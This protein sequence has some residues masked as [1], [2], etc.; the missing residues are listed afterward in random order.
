MKNALLLFSVLAVTFGCKKEESAPFN[1]TEPKALWVKFDAEEQ[2]FKTRT[3]LDLK[4][5]A[6]PP[7]ADTGITQYMI[8]FNGDGAW[9][10]WIT[11]YNTAKFELNSKRIRKDIEVR[12][13]YSIVQSIPDGR[14]LTGKYNNS[15]SVDSNFLL[16]YASPLN[17]PFFDTV[18]EQKF[19][20]SFP[21]WFEISDSLD[22][23]AESTEWKY[24]YTASLDGYDTGFFLYSN[25]T[26]ESTNP[27]YP[28][29]YEVTNLVHNGWL[30]QSKKIMVF[31]WFVG[32]PTFKYYYGWMELSVSESGSLT[33]HKVVYQID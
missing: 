20:S 9:E 15:T 12:V 21:Q 3:I 33:I 30:G 26:L 17:S 31:K 1:P 10:V 24:K 27:Q 4:P 22:V 13:D 28:T 23:L 8:D 19:T 25:R 7:G 18:W 16:S 11:Q 14:V 5:L 32:Q 29:H 2:P 6:L